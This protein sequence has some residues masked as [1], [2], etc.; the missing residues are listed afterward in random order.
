MRGHERAYAHARA[1]CV[2]MCVMCKFTG[3]VCMRVQA[4]MC[5]P[6][7]RKLESVALPHRGMEGCV[8]MCVQAY[9][10]VCG[11]APVCYASLRVCAGGACMRARGKAGAPSI[12][13]NKSK[14]CKAQGRPL[15]K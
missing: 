9:V 6:L 14:R 15:L 7:P 13:K 8:H 10:W 4:C 2:P 12:D 5:S 11:H 1:C 3:R